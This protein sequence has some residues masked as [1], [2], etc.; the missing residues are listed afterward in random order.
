MHMLV[1]SF[2]LAA[3]SALAGGAGL[4]AQDEE[5]GDARTTAHGVY[6]EAQAVRG[7]DLYWNI[8]SECHVEDDFGGPFMQSWSG[9]SVKALL[10]EIQATMPEDNPG[11][12]PAN[13]YI[14]VISYM[15]MLSG[16]PV[17]DEEM[18]ESDLDSIEID[19][20]PSYDEPV[21]GAD[22]TAAAADSGEADDS[23]DA[24]AGDAP[25]TAHGVYSEE[26]AARGEELFWNICSECHVED[27]FGGPFIQSWS[28]VTVKDLLEE[29]Q[30][31]MPEDNPGGLPVNQYIDVISY[32]FKLSGLP[33][34]DEEMTE[35][36]IDA[37]DIEW[38]PPR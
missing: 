11:G 35:S 31:T 38:S 37:I 20:R 9:T 5:T 26:Q 29:I 23:T 28:G 27:D 2:G 10:E 24:D 13:Q 32:M 21:A 7:E 15:F 19:W 4:V 25:T 8:C 6:N 22:E 36:N 18:A 16:M 34:G 3:F 33:A 30:A 12:L 1:R 17:G 14:D